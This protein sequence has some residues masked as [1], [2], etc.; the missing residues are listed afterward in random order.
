[1]NP[2][3]T[4]EALRI[5]CESSTSHGHQVVRPRWY[6]DGQWQRTCAGREPPS[7]LLLFLGG[8]ASRT[9]AVIG[10]VTQGVDRAIFSFSGVLV[11]SCKALF[12]IWCL[13]R[14][15][16]ARALLLICTCQFSMK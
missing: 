16:D 9:P 10:G 5:C 8:N 12:P 6:G 15:I 13:R 11:K 7:Y 4:V 2:T 3:S 1:M 14:E